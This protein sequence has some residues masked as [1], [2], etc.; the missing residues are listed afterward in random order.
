MKVI[1]II[2][3]NG[4]IRSFS[5]LYVTDVKVVRSDLHKNW[6]IDIDLA[7]PEK[8]YTITCDSE[9]DMKQK[10][11]YVKECWESVK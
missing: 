9:A 7:T 2:E 11:Q 6:V 3:D 10:Y 5:P 4:N 1:E 8:I